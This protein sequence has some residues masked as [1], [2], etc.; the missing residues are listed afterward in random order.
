VEAALAG[1]DDQHY[2]Q[3]MMSKPIRTEEVI[4][5]LVKAH[6]DRNLESVMRRVDE[7]SKTV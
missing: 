2:K 3:G 5:M 1:D 4:E 7:L 6:R